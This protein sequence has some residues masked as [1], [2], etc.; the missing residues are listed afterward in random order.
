MTLQ[1]RL[2]DVPPPDHLPEQF[3]QELDQFPTKYLLYSGGWDSTFIGLQLYRKG[4]DCT[5]IWNNTHNT[6]KTQRNTIK[7]FREYT[8]W[9]FLELHPNLKDI[10][11]AVKRSFHNL[12]KALAAKKA[13]KHSSVKN[14]FPCCYALKKK[15][16]NL[17]YKS[18][19]PRQKKTTC[20]ILGLAGY[21]AARRQWR[22]AELR[23]DNT[24]I[25]LNYL[26]L[27][28]IYPLRDFT[29]YKKR[30]LIINYL[31][32][33][34]LFYDTQHTGCVLCP[35]LLVYEDRITGPNVDRRKEIARRFY[36]RLLTQS[37]EK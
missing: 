20:F 29:N 5:I 37:Q 6:L 7:K 26:K 25:R 17:I 22:L 8:K 10:K 19:T 15:P 9:D 18:L 13:Q 16:F 36:R 12:E 21:E 35:L 24:F 30:Q 11:T 23:R 33:D 27:N 34:P 1:T 28:Y 31:K 3:Y 2:F 14:L 32:A 4:I